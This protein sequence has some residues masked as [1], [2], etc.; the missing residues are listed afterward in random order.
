MTSSMIRLAQSPD[1]TLAG[2]A[3][4][5][6]ALRNRLD[7]RDERGMSTETVIITA[8]L[9]ILALAVVAII[10]NKVTQKANSIPTN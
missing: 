9:A 8:G 4:A 7:L 1:P 6:L 10:T 2:V 3:M 5:W